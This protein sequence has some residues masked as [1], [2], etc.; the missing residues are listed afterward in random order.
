ML[1]FVSPSRPAILALV[2]PLQVGVEGS[3]TVE[4]L[5]AFPEYE[6]NG[7]VAYHGST[8]DRTIICIICGIEVPNSAPQR[9]RCSEC[10]QL[11][12]KG[13]LRYL[14]AGEQPPNGQPLRREP[15][16]HGYVRLIWKL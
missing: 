14:S 9:K 7:L 4:V 8:S 1:E 16:S 5:T 10:R 11:H 2:D 15:T 6:Y 13:R 12:F 3:H